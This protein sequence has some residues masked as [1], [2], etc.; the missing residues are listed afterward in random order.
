MKEKQTLENTRYEDG[1][2]KTYDH[3]NNIERTFDEENRLIQK[4][5]PE[6]TL[7]IDYEFDIDDS[8]GK[9]G[10]TRKGYRFEEFEFRIKKE[11]EATIFFLPII[12][13]AA[14]AK[15]RH[16]DWLDFALEISKHKNLDNFLIVAQERDYKYPV[17][18]NPK[19]AFEGKKNDDD[20]MEVHYLLEE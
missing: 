19:R 17:I 4:Q 16:E 11:F 9:V 13:N 18:I 2:R 1:G 3:R 7:T 5:D 10:I 12:G 15:G 8:F 6:K 14:F 20:E